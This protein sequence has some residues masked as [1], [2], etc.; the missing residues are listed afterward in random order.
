MLIKEPNGYVKEPFSI[1]LFKYGV[2]KHTFH[3]HV[4]TSLGEIPES[5]YSFG[6]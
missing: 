4:R 2:N 3:R 5:K 6:Q 1:A